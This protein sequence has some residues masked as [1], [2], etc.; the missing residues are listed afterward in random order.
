MLVKGAADSRT[1]DGETHYNISSQI[2]RN[3]SRP[4]NR[5]I[6]NINKVMIVHSLFRSSLICSYNPRNV[7]RVHV[8]LNVTIKTRLSNHWESALNKE[9]TQQWF[10]LCCVLLLFAIAWFLCHDD[11]IKWKHFPRYWPFAQ[12]PG[13]FPTQRPVTRSFDVFFNLL[14]NKGL[15]KQ[16]RGWWFETLSRPLWRQC[17]V[18]TRAAWLHCHRNTTVPFSGKQSWRIWI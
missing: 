10:T 4:Y 16:S 1:R 8:I 12:V 15:S 18:L 7:I 11:V 3:Y 6:A 17:N 14:L 2:Q 9:N 5:G 13:E